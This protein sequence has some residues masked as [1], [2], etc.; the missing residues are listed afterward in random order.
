MT[1]ICVG[2]LIV[3]GSD[4]CLAP[5]RRHSITETNAG[6]FL[7]VPIRPNFSEM[8]IESHTFSCKNMHLNI[9][10]PKWRPIFHGLIALNFK[11]IHLV[12]AYQ[13]TFI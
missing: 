11:D 8:L 10:S 7:I 13:F 12:L 5:G 4:N 1:Q 3:I 9:L 2:K 6:I